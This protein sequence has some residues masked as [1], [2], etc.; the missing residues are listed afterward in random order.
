M[1]N[2]LLFNCDARKIAKNIAGGG[3]TNIT[4]NSH[5]KAVISEESI[6]YATTSTY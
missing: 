3:D 6:I 1:L 2:F 4:N 5:M